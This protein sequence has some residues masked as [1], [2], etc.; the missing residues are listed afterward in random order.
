MSVSFLK[1]LN[2]AVAILAGLTG[3]AHAAVE[4][5]YSKTL[6]TDTVDGSSYYTC[7]DSSFTIEATGGV[8]GGSSDAGQFVFRSINGD[9]DVIAQVSSASSAPVG[10]MIREGVN[11]DARQVAVA[12]ENG[13]VEY[14][15]RDVSGAALS[16]GNYAAQ[17][18]WLRLQRAG[19]N[20]S[21]Y[22]S[23]DGSNWELLD[24][25]TLALSS[26]VQVGLFVSE[27]SATF[28]NVVLSGTVEDLGGANDNSI[29]VDEG[30]QVIDY[31]E[32]D[33]GKFY[34]DIVGSTVFDAASGAYVSSVMGGN[35]W[36]N[37]DNFHYVYREITGDVQVTVRVD[38]LVGNEE[39]AR[40]GVMLRDSLDNDAIHA[41]ASVSVA[42]GV[43]LECRKQIAGGTRRSAKGGVSAPAWIRLVKEQD[44]VSS[45]YSVDGKNWDL[46]AEEI[47]SYSGSFF[48]GLATVSNNADELA[49]ARYSNYEV[50][51]LNSDDTTYL[52]T[53]IG[54]VGSMGVSFYDDSS[55]SFLV[56][57][58]GSDIGG[59][60]D[61]FHY[62]YRQVSGDFEAITQVSSLEATQ[63]WAKAGLM[64]R[65]GLT[66]SA[67]NYSTLLTKDYG[68][69]IISRSVEGEAAS[70]SS[71]S[72]ASAPVWVKVVRQGNTLSSYTSANGIDWV[73]L[74]EEAINFS[75]TVFVGLAVSAR[76]NTD[77]ALV[78]FAQLQVNN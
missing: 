1:Q 29:P 71:I 61:S 18:S 69:A 59:G 38:S 24:V 67:V 2:L 56:E 12:L 16:Y 63:G 77:L 27:G 9:V 48:V 45:Y 72:G 46:L 64:V 60:Q 62:V 7:S 55:D 15:H 4:T 75:N 39:L 31:T 54:N 14:V 26:S 44:L 37:Q 43:A 19:D 21:V 28:S 32:D 36:G 8:L 34:G 58:S 57:A 23:A 10:L 74:S 76:D 6:A 11:E 66:A 13:V 78:Q 20:F 25:D 22:L 52:S 5:F 65:E 47:I 17:V 42:K 40:G 49:E 33:L 73:Y 51:E 35:V 41:M 30:G 50:V 3:G 53:D 70:L 68:T